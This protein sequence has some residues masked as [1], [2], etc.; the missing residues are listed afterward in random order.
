MVLLDD[1]VKIFGLAQFNINIGILLNAFDGSG[2]GAV[3]VDNDFLGY[4]VQADATLQEPA[5]CS[6][7]PLCGK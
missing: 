5:C 4:I 2:V 3:L 1:V 6:F 7:I